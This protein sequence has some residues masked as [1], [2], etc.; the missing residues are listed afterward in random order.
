MGNKVSKRNLIAG[1]VTAIVAIIGG[2]AGYYFSGGWFGRGYELGSADN[3]VKISSVQAPFATNYSNEDKIS[4]YYLYV[5]FNQPVTDADKIGVNFNSG[6]SINPDIRGSWQWQNRLQLA[7]IPETDW[8][9][10]TT[11][12]VNLSKNIF[13]TPAKTSDL[14]FKFNTPTF[15]GNVD[16]ADFYEDPRDLKNKSVTASFKFTAPID[17][18]DLKDHV[19]IRTVSGESYDFDYKLTN[20]N[21]ILHIISKPVQIKSEEDFAKISVANLGNSYNQKTLYKNLEATVKIPS[22]DTFFK[23]KN[24]G[25]YI[26]RNNKNNNPEQI[27]IAEFTTAVNSQQLQKALVLNY[28]NENC[29]KVTKQWSTDAGKEE[30]FKK[31]K[32][33]DI[34]AIPLQHDN[35]KFHFFKYDESQNE[36]CLLAVFDNEL[37]SVE[38]F[39]LGKDNS[40]TAIAVNYSPYPLEAGIAFDG[41]VMSLQGSRKIAFVSRGAKELNVD[42]ARVKEGDLNHL[43][44]QTYAFGSF[45]TP[46]FENYNFSEA[47]ISEIFNKKLPINTASPAEANYSSLDLN[48]YFQNRKGVFLITVKGSNGNRQSFADKRLILLTDLG[49]VVKDNADNTHNVFVSNIASETPVANVKV[50][51]LGKNGLPVAEAVANEQG[52]AQLPDFSEFKND[53]YAVAY[54]VISGNDISFLPINREDRKLNLSRFDVGGDYLDGGADIQTSL[55]GYI[56]SDRGI[57]RPGENGHLGILVR[58]ADLNAPQKLPFELTIR[59]PNGDVLASKTLQSNEFGFM[60]Y[61]FSLSA[62]AQTGVYSADL[63]LKDKDDNRRFVAYGA[64]RVE[65]FVPDTLKIKANWQPEAPKGWINDSSLKAAVNLQ[66]LYGNPAAEHT[67]QAQYSLT[68]AAFNFADFAGYVFRDPQQSKEPRSYNDYLTEVQTDKDGNAELLLDLKNFEQGT[69]KLQLNIDGLEAGSARGTGTS[70]TALVS[71]AKYLVGW[72]ADDALEYVYKDSAHTVNFVAVDNNLQPLELKD[73]TLQLV[74][75][76]YISSLV[77]QKNG[78]YQYQM[79]AKEKMLQNSP[80]SISAEGQNEKLPTAQPGEYVWKVTDAQNQTLAKIEFYVAGAANLAQT[81]DRN[82]SLNVKLNKQEYAAGDT[83][84]MQIS[85]PYAGY[86]LITVERDKVYAYKWFKTDTANFSQDIVLPSGIEG[87]AYVNVSVFRSLQSDEIYSSPL[88]YAVVPFN[89]NKENRKLNITLDTPATVKPG[90]NLVVNYKTSEP[91]QIVVYGV[92]EGILQVARYKMPKLLDIF[93]AKRALRVITEQ[94]MDLIMPDI[95]FLKN[96]SSTGGDGGEEESALD[97]NI[98]PFARKTDKPVAFWSGIL[99]SDENGGSYT[100]AVPATFNGNIK[101]MAVA[102]SAN[103]FGN[104]EQNVLSRGD[105]ALVPSGPLNVAPG[106]EFVVGLSVGNLV[107]NSGSDYK[108]NVFANVSEGLEII[109]ESAQNTVVN[110]NGETL[111]NFR[112]KAKDNLGSQQITFTAQSVEEQSRHAVMPYTLSVRPAAPYSGKFNFGQA[113][114]SYTL[115]QAEDLYDEYRVQQLSASVSPLVLAQGLLKYLNK[116]PHYCTEQTISKVFPAVE[117]FFKSPDLVKGTDVYALFDD[118]IRILRERQV[119]GGGFTAWSNPALDVNARDTLYATHFL[120]TAKQHGFNVPDGLLDAALGY[121]ELI[122]ARQPISEYD[123]NSAYAA[124]ILTL[125]GKI[126]T[127]Y[128]LNIEEFYKNN[129]AKNW[130]INLG[131]EFLAASYKMLQDEK[132]AGNLAGMYKN[133]DNATESA[134]NLYLLAKHFPEKMR[135]LDKESVETLLEPLSDGNFTTY[136]AGWS[137]LAL[138]A[139]NS[140]EAD[141][142]IKFS[143]F[144]PVY[145]PFPTVNYLPQTKDLS[146]SAPQAFYYANSQQGFAKAAQIKAAAKGLSVSKAVTDKNGQPVTKA[147]LGDVLTVKV[148]YS[149][150]G[151]EPV[152]D[153]AVTDL[154]AGCFEVVEGSLKTESGVESTELRED[155]I[156]VYATAFV[157]EQSFSYQ[158]KVVAEGTYALPPVYADAMYQPLLR[159]NSDL[160]KITVG[161]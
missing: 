104:A 109:G 37:T 160:R 12:K 61:D 144:T 85:A 161:E 137:V 147:K 1:A 35:S 41:S 40:S 33:L 7:F 15:S 105:F 29:Y 78:T 39:K 44:T 62:A 151:K 66:N 22:S 54:K 28:V 43:V 16:S 114:S 106:D 110:E 125:S 57:Y 21:T 25:S 156:N 27:F 6:I 157:Y 34:S 149:S 63:W 77:E 99:P 154:L 5:N 115:E 75:K 118:A 111:L 100:Y 67:V 150:L 45:E 46:Y 47:D 140:Q 70:L 132:R 60:E 92:N 130:R 128:L 4:P 52:M 152:S 56:F 136:S 113:K 143:Q 2:L 73:L 86:G 129:Y 142:K 139:F 3:V 122:A 82:A 32:K 131:A 116:Y 83:L 11:Y 59:K 117:L 102:V 107:E 53:K 64:F 17:T 119:L 24:T 90:E 108:I 55:K 87:N 23:I 38:G 79:V 72:K 14:V 97:R 80:F 69:Y 103:R 123:Y 120:V 158:V 42:I 134:I 135:K 30:L 126:T 141:K 127:N 95:R 76:E 145:T 10:S 146:V 71:P 58:Q 138:N 51:V 20:H 155:R 84:E 88:S 96:L 98:N 13:S 81:N 48:D 8:L 93:L 74:K 121:C 18:T 94:I 26:I 50:Q 36:G 112:F 148:I 101:V 133:R 159:A 49:I 153:V 91:A 31:M 124:Y 9:P 89:I 65:E 19:K 68:P